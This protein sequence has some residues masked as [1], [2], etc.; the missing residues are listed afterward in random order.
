L[1]YNLFYV[2][3]KTQG[4]SEDVLFLARLGPQQV[5]I[6]VLRLICSHISDLSCSF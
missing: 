4:L 2:V 1:Y 6:G 5:Y 3:L